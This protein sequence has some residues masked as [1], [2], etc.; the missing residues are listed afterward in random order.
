MSVPNWVA[1][2]IFYQIFPDRFANGD[3]GNDPINVK[4]WGSTPTAHGFMGGDLRGVIQNLDYLLDLGINAIY[5]NPIFLSSSTHR[6]NTTDYY[7]ID[8]RLG[9]KEDFDNLIKNAHQKNMRVI[10]DGVFNHCGRGFFAFND[11]LENQEYSPYK[12]WFHINRFP[13]DAYTPGDA[14]DYLG[15][16]KH[17]SL[18]KFKTATPEVRRYLLEVSRYWIEQGIDG[19]RLDV[20]NE[21][22]DDGFWAEFREGVRA[23]NPDAYLLGEIWD[24]SPRWVGETHFD[25]LMNYPLRTAFLDLLTRKL[26]G[27]QFIGIFNTLIEAYPRENLYAMYQLLGCHDT[28]RVLTVL[29][30]DLLKLKL[31]Y[32][33]QFTFPGCPAIYYGDEVGLEGGK[34]PECRKAFPWEETLWKP[35]LRDWVQKLTDLRN[36]MP[37]LRRG[38]IKFLESHNSKNAITFIRKL[39]EEKILVVLNAADTPTEINVEILD[40]G[41]HDGQLLRNLIGMEEYL[42]SGG[43]LRIMLPPLGGCLL[44]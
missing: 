10:L 22:D 42:V 2:A 24:L 37:A 40:I 18:P 31:A 44:K 41:C 12:E 6:Y 19:W 38:D 16:W 35:G 9:S 34:D 25:G 8:P 30:G 39:N 15:W 36:Q 32:L 3:T 28:E 21:I 14:R 43:S 20:P 4:P 17:K 5:L 29:N 23:I 27:E 1:D 13:I 7:R 11:I 33:L 26:T